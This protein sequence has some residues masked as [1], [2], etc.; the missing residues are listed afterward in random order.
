MTPSHKTLDTANL[1]WSE[2][3]IW[4]N[5]SCPDLAAIGSCMQCDIYR[6]AGHTLLARDLPTAQTACGGNPSLRHVR[7]NPVGS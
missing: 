5:R 6:Q 3:G 7:E 2:T 4:G 1:C